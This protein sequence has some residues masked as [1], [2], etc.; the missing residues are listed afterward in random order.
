[1]RAILSTLVLTTIFIVSTLGIAY[2][3]ATEDSVLNLIKSKRGIVQDSLYYQLYI[4]FSYNDIDKARQYAEK[5]RSLATE[6]KND[7]YYIRSL[8]A[9]GF[10]ARRSAN[11]KRA[12]SYYSEGLTKALD[13]NYKLGIVMLYNDMGL[14]SY[15]TQQLDKAVEYY[16]K[17]VDNAKKFK[18]PFDEAIA[19]NN[20]ASVYINLGNYK[21]A[22]E[23]YLNC[24]KL[25]EDNSIKVGIEINYCNA[26]LCYIELKDYQKAISTFMGVKNGCTN[27]DLHIQTFY[28]YG[29]GRTYFYLKDYPSAINFLSYS[30]RIAK[31]TNEY[32]RL[33]NNYFLLG[34]TFF[35]LNDLLKSKAYFDSAKVTAENSGNKINLLATYNEYSLIYQKQNDFKTALEYKEK[36]IQLRDSLFKNDLQSNINNSFLSFQKSQSDYIIQGKESQILRNRKFAY[37][38]TIISLL[39]LIILAFSYRTI[40]YRRRLSEILNDLVSIKTKELTYINAKLTKSGKELDTF[41]YRTSHDIRGPIATLLGLTNLALLESKDMVTTSYLKRIDLTADRLN[42]IISRLTNVSQINSM[43][44]D[45]TPVNLYTTVNEVVED[46]RNHSGIE[47][48]I[49]FKLDGNFPEEVKTDNILLKIILTNLL[50]N[51]F[52]FFDPGEKE[53]I[54]ELKININGMLDL[55]ILDNG[56]GINPEFREK[57]FEL[58]FVA[59]DKR[60]SG[61][62]L[63]QAQLATQ[64]LGGSISV[65]SYR[66]PTSF[67]VR[68][69]LD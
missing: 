17:S 49:H 18:F 63:Y 34:Q 51:G 50:E 47:N 9:L 20:I 25:K 30:L 28:N 3:Q 44:L 52:K 27:C 16:L 35:E 58:F 62:G 65:T 24:I 1:M 5:V 19:Y 8:H 4:M 48:G 33:I 26:G 7:V 57:I 2:S 68:I 43:P 69:P 10:L 15:E 14:V 56:I 46:I 59:S 37:I 6:Q 38:I 32:Q 31:S 53:S 11:Y 13:K 40:T 36:Y 64:K 29:L 23:Y 41:L 60:G 45:I 39:L 61:L 67:L 66:K 54:V 55:N 21:H 12:L 42:E 22:L